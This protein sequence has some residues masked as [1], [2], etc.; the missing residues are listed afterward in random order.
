MCK[1]PETAKVT[2]YGVGN[3]TLKALLKLTID[4]AFSGSLE[5]Y[6]SDYDSQIGKI[7]Q[8]P[9]WLLAHQSSE[10]LREVFE[11]ADWV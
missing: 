10:C 3:A 6:F 2:G 5:N 8:S 11:N 7:P 4:V 1:G 9:Q